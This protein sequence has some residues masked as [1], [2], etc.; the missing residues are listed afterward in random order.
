MAAQDDINDISRYISQQVEP[1]ITE[2]RQK[3]YMLT[4]NLI[5]VQ[6]ILESTI[7]KPGDYV[8]RYND[9]M[10]WDVGCVNPDGTMDGS[11]VVYKYGC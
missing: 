3:I 8:G 1:T 9:Y 6:K 4:H 2:L 5:V 10:R 7:L 11:L